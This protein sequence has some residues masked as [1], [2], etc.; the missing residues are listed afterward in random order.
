MQ[1]VK[2]SMLTSLGY[3]VESFT[4]FARYNNGS[5]YA[6]EDVSPEE[7]ERV[8][9]DKDSIGKAFNR[10]REGRPGTKLEDPHK[11]A[12]VSLG[13]AMK[14][15][16][17]KQAFPGQWDSRSEQT[18]PRRLPE[19]IVDE[20][21]PPLVE[22]TTF[23]DEQSAIET[24]LVVAAKFT[25]LQKIE[26]AAQRVTAAELL[27]EIEREKKARV[28]WFKPIKKSA[29]E[30]WK[31][32]CDRENEALNPLT[33]ARAS[34]EALMRS[35]DTEAERVRREQEKRLREQQE[36]DERDRAKREAEELRLRE[37]EELEAQGRHEE[38]SERLSAPIVSV[39]RPQ[40][41]VILPSQSPAV[42]GVSSRKKFTFRIDNEAQLP[43]EY[44]MPDESKIRRVVDA[45][46]LDAKIPGIVVSDASGYG[47]NVRNADR[48]KRGR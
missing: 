14:E 21:K 42:K 9:G 18:P 46:G 32:I 8:I 13:D 44:M 25:A 26:N 36:K 23:T 1:P 6:Y 31:S 28:E 15:L 47:V 22:P 37:A 19:P 16:P 24:A 34:I 10:L 27:V 38:V 4:L 35:Y 11:M 33:L 39:P 7:Y 41:A 12:P 48:G 43:R 30:T 2:S 5:L 3:D 45:L 40:P 20:V 29:H 17:D